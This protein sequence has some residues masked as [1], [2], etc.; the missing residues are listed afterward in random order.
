MKPSEFH[1][2]VVDLFSILVPGSIFTAIVLFGPLGGIKSPSDSATTYWV[3]FLIS[4]YFCG[5]LIYGA[6]ALLDHKGLYDRFR[7]WQ[8]PD[9]PGDAYSEVTKL[10]KEILGP[11]SHSFVNNYKWAKSVL[12]AKASQGMAEVNRLEADSKFFRSLV[13]LC[14]VISLVS[15]AFPQFSVSWLAAFLP[16]IASLPGWAMAGIA[17]L[18]TLFSFLRYAALRRKSCELAY[19]HVIVLLASAKD[20]QAKQETK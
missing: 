18:L 13:I 3:V 1:I 15:L 7:A 6:G 8:W 17:V 16:K 20:D 11:N 10:K 2:G 4:S 14:G 19:T 12:M 5:H 9:E